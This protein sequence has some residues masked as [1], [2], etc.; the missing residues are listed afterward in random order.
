MRS[1]DKGLGTDLS[2]SSSPESGTG[3]L[4]HA[5]KGEAFGWATIMPTEQDALH[6]LGQAHQR[7]EELGW[8][9][10][11]YCPKD[12]SVFDAIEA[13]STGIHDCIY[14]GKWPTG[15]WW[16]LADGDMWPSRPILY[17][18]KK[19]GGVKLPETPDAAS[20]D[21][22]DTAPAKPNGTT[23]TPGIAPNPIGKTND[24]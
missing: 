9:N 8:R 5:N 14:E 6:V 22:Q 10:A 18:E 21:S 23:Q 12:G 16:V 11:I 19:A 1:E 17:R 4:P 24:Q 3:P 20:V 2:P 7:L 13:G 15:G